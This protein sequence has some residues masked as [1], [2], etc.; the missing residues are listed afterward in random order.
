V[1]FYSLKI[2]RF[3]LL[4]GGLFT[5]TQEPSFSMSSP[6]VRLPA[7]FYIFALGP[8][9]R[10]GAGQIIA[11]LSPPSPAMK[12]FRKVPPLRQKE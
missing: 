9:H 11:I 6:L 3:S 10:S 1:V 12:Y 8:G 2:G 4:L 7:E 5:C